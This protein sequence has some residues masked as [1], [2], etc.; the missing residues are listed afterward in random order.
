VRESLHFGAAPYDFVVSL[1][2]K[3]R[4]RDGGPLAVYAVEGALGTVALILA[5]LG[6]ILLGVLYWIFGRV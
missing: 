3:K 4:E 1:W 5:V 6:A 2:L